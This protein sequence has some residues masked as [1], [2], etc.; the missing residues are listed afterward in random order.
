MNVF[1]MCPQCQSEYEN[2][3]D[4]RYHA[5]PNACADCGPQVSLYQNKKRL[6]NI[7][8][9]EEAVELLKKGK[10]GAIKGLGGFHLACDATNNKVVARLRWLKI[11]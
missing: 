5:Q 6:E 8:P 4:R 11:E 1:K 9:I 10:I 2:I 3:E 7:D